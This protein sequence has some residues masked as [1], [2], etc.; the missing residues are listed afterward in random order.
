MAIWAASWRTAGKVS[1]VLGAKSRPNAEMDEGVIAALGRA[2]SD[3][4]FPKDEG[5]VMSFDES[6][7]LRFDFTKRVELLVQRVKSLIAFGVG[8]GDGICDR[9]HGEGLEAER[10]EGFLSERRGGRTADGFERRHN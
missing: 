8:L 7:Q 4:H 3:E 1:S 6:E 9:L 2:G 5:R 10:V